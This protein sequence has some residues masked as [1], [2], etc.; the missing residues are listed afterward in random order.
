MKPIKVGVVGC[1]MVAQIMHLPHLKELKE[2]E[3]QAVCDASPKLVKLI[4]DFYDVPERYTNYEELVKSDLDVVMILTFYHSDIAKAAARE[5]KHI[6]CEKPLSFSPQEAE[7]MIKAVNKAKVKLMVAYMKRYDEGYLLGQRLFKK[8]KDLRLI[9]V[10][11]VCFEN[12]LALRTMF[13]LYRFND[14]NPKIIKETNAKFDFRVRQAL[15]KAPGYVD[16]AYR[17]MLE[18]A[19]HDITILR[20]AFGDPEKIIATSIWPQGDFFASLLS[21][22]KDVRCI[23]EAGRTKRNWFDEELTA[24][25]MKETISIKFPNPFHKNAPTIV[26]TIDMDGDKIIRKEVKASHCESFKCELKSFADC[27]INDKEPLTSGEEGLKDTQ[28]M[29]KMI[30]KYASS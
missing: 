27:I 9:R 4:G 21:Y 12:E 18:L 10:H 5:G 19:S 23:F 17:L 24:Y 15:G 26:E 3:I 2:F 22:G 7:E 16:K 6:F 8:M 29:V 14:I 28:L 25:G 11:D 30:K 1:G 13:N 20:A